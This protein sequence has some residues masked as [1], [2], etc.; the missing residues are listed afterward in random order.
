MKNKLYY[1]EKITSLVT[2]IFLETGDAK[3]R[4]INCEEKIISAH[5]ASVG[6]DVPKEIQKIWDNYWA[7]LN[8]I[9]PWYDN[10]GR[11]IQSSL[12][13]TVSRKRNKSMEKYLLFFLEEFFRV[14]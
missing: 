1:K 10:E 8:V 11:L 14:L 4:I 6:E 7:E 12:V 5:I 9:E 13:G 2:K 3:S